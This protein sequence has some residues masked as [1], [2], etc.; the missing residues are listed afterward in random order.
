MNF[1]FLQ[2]SVKRDYIHKDNA[3]GANNNNS[4]D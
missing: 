1:I 2:Q 3:R 4:V